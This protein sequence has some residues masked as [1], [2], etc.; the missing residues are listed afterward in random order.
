[1][2]MKGSDLNIVI[3]LLVFNLAA[4]AVAGIFIPLFMSAT[5]MPAE[6][7][8]FFLLCFAAAV[9]MS[10]VN[11]IITSIVVLEKTIE[12]TDE[13][14]TIS[15]GDLRIKIAKEKGFFGRIS[16]SINNMV[17]GVREIIKGV[18]QSTENILT[19]AEN[20][21]ASTQQI[22]ASS[23]EISSTVQ[24]IARGVEQQ[25]ERTVET[26]RIMEKMS[27][28][29][30][31]V[32]QKSE[33]V[34]GVA[35]AAKEATEKGI[36]TVKET[37]K[38]MDDIVEATNTAKESII[39]LRNY[40]EKIEEVVNIITEI[41]DETNLLALNAAIEAARAGEAGRGFAVVAD[42][43]RKLAEGSADAA[44]EITRLVEDI[45]DR[46]GAVEKAVLTGV[47]ETEEGK[48]SAKMSGDALAEISEV[49]TK[50]VSLSKE[51]FG[52]SK[53]QA[54]DTDKVV[55]AVEEIAAVAEQTAAGTQEASASTEQQ[56]ASMQEIAAQ[57]QELAHPAEVLRGAMSKFRLDSDK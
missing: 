53:A 4:G 37:V 36:G 47:K 56:T 43:V 15:K 25:A 48:K 3:K 26:S 5:K 32:A 27:S 46:T 45:H 29:I 38:K 7:M 39:D 42:E 30:Q 31:D 52:L 18:S 44:K 2:R 19:L 6:G 12:M 33:E 23:E 11:V 13:L 17:S 24:Q 20:L 57:A 14:E 8:P 22:N 1:M 9:G 10:V 51:I 40:S 50:V 21:S 34:L 49:V 54:E 28:S 41:A 55:K 16:G 35:T